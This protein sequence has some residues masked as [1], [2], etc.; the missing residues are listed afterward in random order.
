MIWLY[1]TTFSVGIAI[2]LHVGRKCGIKET[3]HAL[4]V[5]SSRKAVDNFYK[6]TGLNEDHHE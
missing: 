1:I 3:E 5:I 6:N 4:H 2:G